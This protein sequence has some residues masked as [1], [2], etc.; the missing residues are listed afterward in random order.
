MIIIIG[1]SGYIGTAFVAEL[2][3]RKDKFDVIKHDDCCPDMELPC[4]T[5]L[6]INCAI[7]NPGESFSDCERHPCESVLGVLHF[8]MMLSEMCHRRGIPFAQ[9]STGCQWNDGLT[10]AEYDPPQRFFTGYSGFYVGLKILAERFVR[11]SKD[12]YTWRIRL[13]FD[14]FDNRRNY[15]SKLARYDVVWDLDNTIS[16]RGDFVKACLAIWDQRAPFGVYNVCNPGTVSAKEIV[17]RLMTAGVRKQ[18]PSF[19]CVPMGGA[20]SL[21]MDKILDT[22]IAIRSVD[23]ALNEAI[24]NW[25]PEG[26]NEV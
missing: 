3:K 5:E 15:L 20:C 6:I 18:A 26:T 1:G 11:Q 10:H 21:S 2:L 24:K 19:K 9:I 25:V 16:H 4:D 8:P 23:D 17:L 14:E 12:Q 7:Y 13:P 22:G